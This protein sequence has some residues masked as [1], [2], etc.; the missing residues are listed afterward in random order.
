MIA[1]PLAPFGF[2]PMKE[3]AF[4][5]S[6]ACEPEKNFSDLALLATKD[7]RRAFQNTL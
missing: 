6:I 7:S 4:M 5:R 2:S 1:Y 3:S